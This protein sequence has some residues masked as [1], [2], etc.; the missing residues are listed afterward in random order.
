[1]R[2]GIIHKIK[3][4]KNLE[5]FDYGYIYH[6]YSHAN[7]KDLLLK[8]NPIII[9]FWRSFLHILFRLQIFMYTAFS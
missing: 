6:V 2:F 5:S 3:R 4:M 7:G 1:M 8:K 9:I